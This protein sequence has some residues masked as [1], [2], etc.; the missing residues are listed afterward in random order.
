MLKSRS[1]SALEWE[2]LLQYMQSLVGGAAINMAT[3]KMSI[4]VG[5]GGSM[6]VVD[7]VDRNTTAEDTITRFKKF[8]EC[9]ERYEY[10]HNI[11]CRLKISSSKW[12]ALFEEW[13]CCSRPIGDR[14][15]IIPLLKQ[16]GFNEIREDGLMLVKSSHPLRR[17]HKT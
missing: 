1:N 11:Q 5:L 16:W 4:R 9:F 15:K 3:G 13:R 8:T 6:K 2:E 14:E 7:N 10:V 12:C 17:R